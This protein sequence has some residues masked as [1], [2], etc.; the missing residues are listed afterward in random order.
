MRI[1]SPNPRLGPRC[2]EVSLKINECINDIKSELEHIEYQC[3]G[4]QMNRNE[5]R[6][7]TIFSAFIIFK[8]QSRL[9]AGT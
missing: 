1:T 6:N 9:D 2:R 3:Q 7:K 8:K 4:Y 5:M